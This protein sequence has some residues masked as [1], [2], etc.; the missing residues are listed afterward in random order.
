MKYH[1]EI[2]WPP[3]VNTYWRNTKRGVLISKAG[4]IFGQKV[5]LIVKQAIGHQQEL[6]VGRLEVTIYAYPP[7]R[8][9]RDLDNILKAPLD[10]CT[11]GGLWA[12]DSQVDCL[13]IIRGPVR[14]G[15]GMELI[16]Q[17]L[18]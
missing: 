18:K 10:A 9:A 6:H 5:A 14:K 4:R 12:D 3:T 15:G 17:V 16:V 8:R 11:K 7:D 1:I 2:P 13:T